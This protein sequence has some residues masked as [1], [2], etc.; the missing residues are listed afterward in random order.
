MSSKKIKMLNVITKLDIG[1]A[2]EHVIYNCSLLDRNK[3][4]VKL[5]SG[6]EAQAEEMLAMVNSRSL[7]FPQIKTPVS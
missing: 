3:Y 4:K 1:G 5:L 2:Q 6:S 7:T